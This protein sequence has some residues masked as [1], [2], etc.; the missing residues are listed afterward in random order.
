M[1]FLEGGGGGVRGERRGHDVTRGSQVT[2]P[3]GR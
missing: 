3:R 2:K 1:F